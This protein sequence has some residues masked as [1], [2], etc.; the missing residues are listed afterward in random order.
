M[1]RSKL[2]LV[3]FCV[4][5]LGVM[6]IGV[7]AA[8]ASLYTWIVLDTTGTALE[9]A[10]AELVSEPDSKDLTLSTHISGLA[11]AITCT[12][13][14][15]TGFSTE[16]EGKLAAG[17]RAFFEGCEAYGKGAL[18]EPLKCHLHTAGTGSGIIETGQ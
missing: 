3:G 11:V 15:L 4:A 5:L 6:T 9:S 7:S 8:S 16:A 13:L 2:G 14:K 1:T 18:E 12:S 10:K 17:G